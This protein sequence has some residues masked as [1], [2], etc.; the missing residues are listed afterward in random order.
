MNPYIGEIKLFAL[1]F[2]P[3]GWAI[4]AGQL[5]AIR[6]NQALFA[7]LG[8]QYG[9][10][11]QNT[12]A[13]PDL[14][15]R[16]LVGPRSPS[17]GGSQQGAMLGT[18]TVT[19]TQAQMPSHQHNFAGT[20]AAATLKPPVGRMHAADSSAERDFYAPAA[21]GN[22]VTLSPQ[23]LASTGSNLPHSNMQPYLVLNY[24]IALQGIFPS[25]N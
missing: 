17:S 7:L 6:T 20:S 5:L 14:R 9:G 3:K 23:S 16:V 21:D 25:R 1:D 4:C 22:L 18:E 13:L 12:F 19:V 10:D 2:A 11:G 15:G 8:T 24:C